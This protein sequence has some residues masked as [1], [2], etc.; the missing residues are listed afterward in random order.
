MTTL[1]EATDIVVDIGGSRL[2]AG[3][4]LTQ[5]AGAVTAILGPNGAGKSTLLSVLAGDRRP[6]TGSVRFGGILS[7]Q[8][9]PLELARHRSVLRQTRAFDIPFT[10][11]EVVMMGRHPYR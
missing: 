9:S 6:T 2:V 10:V 8:L 4:S 1:L 7:G 11:W 3:V 5:T